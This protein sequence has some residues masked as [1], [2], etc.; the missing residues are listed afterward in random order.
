NVRQIEELVAA[1]PKVRDRAKLEELRRLGASAEDGLTRLRKRL[2]LFAQTCEEG[3]PRA[4]ARVRLALASPDLAPQRRWNLAQ[5]LN[6]LAKRERSTVEAGEV[7]TTERLATE[8]KQQAA[9]AGRVGLAAIGRADFAM[10]D[11]EAF[12]TVS[13]RLEHFLV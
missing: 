2:D 9:R 6:R 7:P 1:P 5:R 4:S 8:E 3:T 13:H 10:R 12:E 11:G